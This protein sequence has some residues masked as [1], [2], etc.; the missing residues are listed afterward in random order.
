MTAVDELS[1][2]GVPDMFRGT[3]STSTIKALAELA[4]Q[5]KGAVVMG[6]SQSGVFPLQAALLNPAAMKGLVLVE[7]G[8]CPATYTADQI[9]AL[10]TVPDP[11]RVRRS[12]RR[13]RPASRRCRHWQPRFELCQ[14]LI[15]RLKGAGGQA[16]M[17]APPDRA[18]T[19]TAT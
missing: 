7:P 9:K 6:H 11:G 3:T 18:S 2:Q 8:S 13:L 14:A 10:A 19:A 1:K 12:P 15:G 4:G 17:L 16:E 5:L